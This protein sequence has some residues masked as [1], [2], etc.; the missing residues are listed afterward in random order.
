M[1]LIEKEHRYA[2]QDTKCIPANGSTVIRGVM[3]P[4]GVLLHGT[5]NGLDVTR[6][7]SPACRTY[8][9]PVNIPDSRTWH[10]GRGTV[11][12]GQ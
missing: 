6:R 5:A 3:N 7:L 1:S 12:I 9:N 11:R 2:P 10:H 4:K 8:I